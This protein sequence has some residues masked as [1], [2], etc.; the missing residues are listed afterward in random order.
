M[1]SRGKA[2]RRALDILFE[3]ELRGEDPMKVLAER[4]ERADPPV[5]EYTSTVVEGVCRHRAR[6]DDLIST[7]A[8]GWTLDRMPA[9]DRNVL[10]GGTYE[11]L[12]APDVPEGVVISEWVHLAAELSTDESPQFVNGLLARFKQLKPSLTL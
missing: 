12:W 11:L 2:R 10:R 9:V 4:F 6:I 7:Y 8:E 3:S 1:S 5:N